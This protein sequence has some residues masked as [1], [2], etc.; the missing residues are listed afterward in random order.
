MEPVMIRVA[1]QNVPVVIVCMFKF[2]NISQACD[3]YSIIF[4]CLQVN[5][6]MLGDNLKLKI[7]EENLLLEIYPLQFITYIF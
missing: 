5:E 2:E 6:K 3:L 1:R 7:V 4:Y